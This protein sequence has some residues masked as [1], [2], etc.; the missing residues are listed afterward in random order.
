MKSNQLV[1]PQE[2]D[3]FLFS[4][5]SAAESAACLHQFSVKCVLHGSE[6]AD[7]Y[8]AKLGADKLPGTP[9]A[10][11]IND[12]DKVCTESFGYST[13]LMMHPGEV[14]LVFPATK[15]YISLKLHMS[16][17]GCW[18]V[19]EIDIWRVGEHNSQ[20]KKE[21]SVSCYVLDNEEQAPKLK[22]GHH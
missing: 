6:R 16:L 5:T 13:R 3:C 8:V 21:G 22:I 14:Q 20:I 9:I 7:F 1:Y 11:K 12:F 19:L 18:K 17:I 10:V 2:F 4:D 15:D